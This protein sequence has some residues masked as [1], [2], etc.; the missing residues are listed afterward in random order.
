MYGFGEPSGLTPDTSLGPVGGELPV[1]ADHLGWGWGDPPASGWAGGETDWGFGDPETLAGDHI[2]WVSSK[3]LPDDGGELITLLSAW[4]EIGPWRVRLI[5][6]HTGQIFPNAD[7]PLPY[8]KSPVPGFGERCYTNILME[9]VGGV[10]TPTPG[11]QLSFV[12]PPLPTGKYDCELIPPTGAGT[13][14]MQNVMEVI[15]RNRSAEVYV[16]RNRWP[17]L[18]SAGQRTLRHEELLGYDKESEEEVT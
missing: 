15:W 8:C 5:Q 2:L 3:E 16:I 18:F 6:T 10:L 7:A 14:L 13:V 9:T 12:L 1:T 4:T 17:L 11:T